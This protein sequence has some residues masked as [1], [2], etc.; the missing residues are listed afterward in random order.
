MPPKIPA[1]H[2][3]AAIVHSSGLMVFSLPASNYTRDSSAKPRFCLVPDL[4]EIRYYRP[5]HR[6]PRRNAMRAE[7]AR[8]NLLTRQTV[9][10]TA[11][12]TAFLAD[13]ADV[14]FH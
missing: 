12:R 14:N 5:C 2:T 6:F 7:R 10:P 1:T 11:G 3:R 4:W 9:K 13:F 8:L